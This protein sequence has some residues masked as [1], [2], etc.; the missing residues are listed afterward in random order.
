MAPEGRPIRL[1]VLSRNTGLAHELVLAVCADL[2]RIAG[3]SV[4]F[5]CRSP[6]L[7]RVASV[8]VQEKDLRAVLPHLLGG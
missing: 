7:A 8:V 4:A 5:N 3:L 1:A 2:A 6:E